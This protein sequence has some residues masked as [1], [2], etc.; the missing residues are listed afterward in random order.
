MAHF[1][2]HSIFLLPLF[3]VQLLYAQSKTING[4]VED[5]DS[6]PV[7]N[8]YIA[9]A[10]VGVTS[11][12]NGTFSIKV[13][14]NKITRENITIKKQGLRM[15][16]IDLNPEKTYLKIRLRPFG[17][18]KGDISKEK[19]K[20]PNARIQIVGTG[21]AT[22][23]D[24]NGR[25]ELVLNEDVD[26]DATTK[27]MVNG[28]V[29]PTADINFRQNYGYVA[30][31]LLE[32][33]PE[34]KKV[35]SIVVFNEKNSKPLKD[36]K[37]IIEDKVYT[38]DA[39]GKVSNLKN[40]TTNNTLRVQGYEIERETLQGKAIQ[41]FV[42]VPE[43]GEELVAETDPKIKE[44]FD[45]IAAE[46]EEQRNAMR[47][48]SKEI[49]RKIASLADELLASNNLNPAQRE[50]LKE[51]MEVLQ[52]TFEENDKALQELQNNT[53]AELN[54]LRK[55]I[56]DSLANKTREEIKRLEQEKEQ[57][58]KNLRKTL[59]IGLPTI[60]FLAVLAII[61]FILGRKLR[62]QNKEIRAQREELTEVNEKMK[63]TNQKMTEQYME[64]QLKNEE[65]EKVSEKVK[66]ANQ[67]MTEQYMEIQLQKDEIQS[68]KDEI[69]EQSHIIEEKNKSLESSVMSAERIQ[70]SLLVNPTDLN[71]RLSDSFVFFKPRDIVSGDF[72]WYSEQG[73]ELVIAALD[74]TGHGVPGAFMTVLGNSILNQIVNEEHITDPAKILTKLDEQVQST[75]RKHPNDY[76]GGDGMDAA[77]LNINTKTKKA[78]FSGAKIPLYVVKS[79]KLEQFKGNNITIGSTL[80][81]KPGKVFSNQE[82]EITGEELFYLASD[83]FQDQHNP[84]RKKYK[85]RT[86]QSLL[87][88]NS[89][90]PMEEQYQVLDKTLKT[91][92]KNAQ[93]TDDI[94]V[95][96]IK[97]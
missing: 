90:K 10:G 97:V 5:S 24:G 51:Y 21:I 68:Q 42:K 43:E 56:N 88:E 48:K 19:K 25:F 58:K 77:L 23:S 17:K 93:Q 44:K 64:I 2:K 8:A 40:V 69:E 38:T 18:L 65:I 4:F 81:R 55:S 13:D 76:G 60:I 9:I 47:E 63:V 50:K 29:I 15:R 31:K 36:I 75:L 41:L 22:T 87:V 53:Q 49:Q 11:N 85:K 20:I 82:L 26:I 54:R 37:V 72:Y 70:S 91:W 27:F 80:F 95:M 39:N 34:G 96:G 73:D 30:I 74:C 71:Q 28:E 78:I 67:E 46:L 57:A 1:I 83:G 59:T 92:Q 52:K 84:E 3:L 66:E 79:D 89:Q 32:K 94:L 16:D 62:K 6:R 86:F 33:L 35:E 12:A 61:F 7:A 14:V 45:G